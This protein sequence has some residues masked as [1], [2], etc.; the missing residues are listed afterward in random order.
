[1]LNKKYKNVV[2]V[3]RAF[4]AKCDLNVKTYESTALHSAAEMGHIHGGADLHIKNF[5]GLTPLET[6]N[7]NEDTALHMAA[8]VGHNE[9]V[10]TPNSS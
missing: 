3:F 4:Q 10:M 6:M 5:Q 7:E 2:V 1:M 8:E 9:V